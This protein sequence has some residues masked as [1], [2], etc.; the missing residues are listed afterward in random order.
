MNDYMEEFHKLTLREKKQEEE[1]ERVAR[2]LNGLRMS[3]LE[4]ISL[5]ALDTL[6]KCFQLALKVKEKLKRQGNH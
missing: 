6:G 3:I 1:L 4:E 5:L 2:Y